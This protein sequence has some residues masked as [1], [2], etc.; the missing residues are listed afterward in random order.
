MHIDERQNLVS[1]GDRLL[2]VKVWKTGLLLPP[3]SGDVMATPR[4]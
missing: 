3:M 4:A 2:D 1:Y